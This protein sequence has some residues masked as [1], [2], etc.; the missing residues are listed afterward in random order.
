[1]GFNVGFNMNDFFKKIRKFITKDVQNEFESKDLA[2]LLRVL[3]ILSAL[4]LLCASIYLAHIEIYFLA[5]LSMIPIGIFLGAFIESYE[6]KTKLSYYLYIYTSVSV[7]VIFTLQTGW[8]KNFQWMAPLSAFVIF[9]SVDIEIKAKIKRTEII[10]VILISVALLSHLIGIH[11]VGETLHNTL[12]AIL[13][14]TY[15]SACVYFTA[16][17][18]SKKFNAS[19]IKLRNY[20]QKLKDMASVDALTLLLNRRSMNEYLSQLVYE[21]DKRGDV[22]SIAIADLDFFKKIND[23][24]GHDAGDFVLKQTAEIF[25]KTMEGRGKV[26][27][28]GGEEFLFCFE[29]LNVSQAFNI[30][31]EMRETIQNTDF[32]FQDSVIHLTITIG[33]EE[34]YHITGIEGTI[35]KADKKLYEGK[36]AGRNRIIM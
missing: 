30:L 35:S 27:R 14:A 17:S 22:F 4:Y 25:K 16:F 10:S 11:K 26:S 24:Y 1:M 6:N 36:T 34:Y 7:A 23:N 15:Y 2:V 3:S 28:W 18:Y 13:T 31:D 21:K 9:Y 8:D 20:N 32:V 33:L 12:F 19:E 29:D 5:V